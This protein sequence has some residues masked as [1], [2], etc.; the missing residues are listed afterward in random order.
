MQGQLKNVNWNQVSR[1]LI[2]CLILIILTVFLGS[3][4]LPVIL[5]LLVA[6]FFAYLI[7]PFVDKLERLSVP[8]T[9]AV[10]LI[11]TFLVALILF[12]VVRLVPILY[13]QVYF[14]IQLVPK[15]TAKF[16][17]E[18]LPVISQYM[19]ENGLASSHEDILS[20]IKEISIVDE[21]KSHLQ[22]GFQGVWAT[23]T[24]LLGGAINAVL[25]P[26]ITLFLV[27][28]KRRLSLNIMRLIPKDL[29]NPVN[30]LI[31]KVDETLQTVIKGQVT[32]ALILAVLYVIGFSTIG[33][34]SGIAIGVVAG[35]CRIIPYFDVVMAIFLSAIVF[36]ADFPGWLPVLGV[37][38]VILVVQTLD[39]MFITPRIIGERIGLHPV[40]VI[41]SLIAF[42]TWFGFWGI[43]LAI[44]TV[45]VIK[46]LWLTGLPYYYASAAYTNTASQ[47]SQ[48]T[49]KS[50]YRRSRTPKPGGDQNK[51]NHHSGKPE[52]KEVHKQ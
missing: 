47:R 48:K 37:L 28:E 18:W 41:V 35:I 11:V 36:M 8:R 9:L 2:F 25:V 10:S 17:S 6:I 22:A 42:G 24:T 5:P 4:Y 49:R 45:A 33:L 43:L 29:R 21:L 30:V 1:F 51:R 50:Y 20:N 34:K 52:K 12:G 15:T 46:V 32:V 23:G 31:A 7:A 26:I 16:Y 40:F 19:V 13:T 3:I 44:P 38:T 27:I 14:L 39:G